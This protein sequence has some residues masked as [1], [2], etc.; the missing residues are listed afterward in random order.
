MLGIPPSVTVDVSI[1]MIGLLE[2]VAEVLLLETVAEVLLLEVGL[3][4]DLLVEEVV[5]STGVGVGVS[6]GGVELGG[7]ELGGVTLGGGV[8]DVATAVEEVV[9]AC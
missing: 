2:T 9:A 1:D 7:V 4:E 3:V 6:E 5:E 8:L